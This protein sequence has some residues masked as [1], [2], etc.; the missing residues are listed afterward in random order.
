MRK[1]ALHQ[2][3]SK[4]PL[5]GSKFKK[6]LKKN[7]ELYIMF[8]P[9]LLFYVIFCYKPMYGLLMAFQNYKPARGI[10]GS[11]WVGLK[12]FSAAHDRTF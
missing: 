7:Y 10:M 9:V 3:G 12:H 2:S 11:Q 6:D 5:P 8:L 1:V 4:K